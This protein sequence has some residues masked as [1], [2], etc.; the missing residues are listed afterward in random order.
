MMEMIVFKKRN[1]WTNQSK[2][3]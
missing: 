2:H 1:T 3:L